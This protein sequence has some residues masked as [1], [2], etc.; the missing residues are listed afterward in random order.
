MKSYIKILNTRYV[1]WLALFVLVFVHS[2]SQLHA[3]EKKNIDSLLTIASIDDSDLSADD[4]LQLTYYQYY[5]DSLFRAMGYA[6]KC[7]KTAKEEGDYL[8]LGLVYNIKGYVHIGFGTYVKAINFFSMAAQLGREHNI[9]KLVVGA[10]HGI[11]RAY[12][13]MGEYDKAL[14]VFKKGLDIVNNDS[15]STNYNA[16]ALYNGVGIAMQNKGLFTESLSYFKK[17]YKLSEQSGDSISMVYALVNMGETFRTDS[18]YSSATEYYNKA[19]ELNRTLKNAQV[20]AAIYGNMASI[21]SALGESDKAKEYLKKGI[22]LCSSNNGL[23]NYL[24]LDYQSIVEEYAKMYQFDSAYI[25]Y[26]KYSLLRDSVNEM[27]RMQTISNLESEYQMHEQEVE[28]KLLNQKLQSR[29][30]VLLFSTALSVLVV[31]LLILTYSRYKLKT[32]V[33]KKEAKELNLT[34]DE[35]NRQLVTRVMDQNK[36]NYAYENLRETLAKIEDSKDVEMVKKELSS[37]LTKLSQDDNLGMDWGSFKMHFEQVHPNFFNALLSKNNALTQND[38]RLCGY[39]KL[40]L[41]T[42]EIANILNVSDRTIQTSR[43]RIKKKLELPAEVNL[44]QY[45]LTV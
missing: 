31:L 25:Y 11:G 23:S 18:N 8:S 5:N 39:I 22:R 3:S 37:M 7:A 1:L 32:R 33:L 2:I 41:S 19:Q 45:I 42:K 27:D 21:Y 30:R 6:R 10:Y 40:N 14:E 16:G 34:I 36:H 17:F 43:Y 15:S 13:D 28:Q 38:L 24:I 9:P 35:K 29:T 26:R 44:V 20:E 4:F 12:N